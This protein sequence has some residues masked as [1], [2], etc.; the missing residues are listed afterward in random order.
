MNQIGEAAFQAAALDHTKAAWGKGVR[1]AAGNDTGH[2]PH[3]E[4][5]RQLE[6]MHGTGVT[7]LDVLRAAILGGWEACGGD[8]GGRRF[9]LLRA[10]WAADLL[11]IQNDTRENTG[12]FRKFSLIMKDWSAVEDFRIVE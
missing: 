6:L 8:W 10:G 11:A 7:L 1:L 4:N 3:G 9:G 2:F 12:A 5:V